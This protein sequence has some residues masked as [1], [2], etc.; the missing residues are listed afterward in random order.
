MGVV[1]VRIGRGEAQVMA[2]LHRRLEQVMERLLHDAAPSPASRGWVP[3]TDIYDTPDGL[4][5]ILDL[6]GIEPQEIEI[7]VEGAYLSVSGSR[8]EPAPIGCMRW[9]Q[10]EI[11]HGPFERIIALPGE[12]DPARITAT[13]EDGFLHISIPR[14]AGGGRLVPI[15][16]R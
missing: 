14:A 9:H 11:A 5:V 10:M 16:E 4:S 13:Y 1:L 3:R 7:V 12:V 6:P 2:D 8:P 15:A